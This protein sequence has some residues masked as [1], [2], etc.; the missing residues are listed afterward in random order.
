M[1]PLAFPVLVVFKN[2]KGVSE[3]FIVK[4]FTK[5]TVLLNV[6]AP[7]PVLYPNSITLA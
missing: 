1:I 5:V 6:A 2:I 3:A 7:L 4:S